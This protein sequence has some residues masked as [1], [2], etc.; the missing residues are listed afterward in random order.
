[1][2]MKNAADVSVRHKRGYLAFLRQFDLT[3]PFAQLGLDERQAEGRVNILLTLARDD[4]V[5]FAQSM[6]IENHPPRGGHC[7]QFI[8]ML[9]RAGGEKERDAVTLLVGQPDGKLTGRI[10]PTL[11][12][13][14]THG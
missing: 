2:R 4:L 11:L 12:S 8:E 7:P 3:A 10:E 14:E 13:T 6:F 5:P 1:M 9:F